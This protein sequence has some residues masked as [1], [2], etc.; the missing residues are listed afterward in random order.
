MAKFDLTESIECLHTHALRLP[1]G[2]LVEHR[3]L[4]V[5]IHSIHWDELGGS[6][7]VLQTTGLPLFGKRMSRSED[8][9]KER[10]FI[11]IG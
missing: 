5:A 11:A 7:E 1:K 6:F 9:S 2:I 10:E 3:V 8:Q 4:C